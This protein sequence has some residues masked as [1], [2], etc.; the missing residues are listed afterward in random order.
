MTPSP[1]ARRRPFGCPP[2]PSVAASRLVMALVLLAVTTGVAAQT[3]EALRPGHPRVYTVQPGDTLWTIAG[4]FLND[5][6]RWREV[7]QA[8]PGVGN[9]NLIFPGDVLE[10]TYDAGGRARIRSKGGTRVV[11]LSPRIRVTEIDEAIP[12]IP[13]SVIAPFLSRPMVS[14]SKEIDGAPYV[15]SFP[16][17]RIVASAGDQFFVR[18]VLSSDNDRYEVLRPGQELI[19]PDTDEVLGYEATFVAEAKLLRT[20]DPATLEVMRGRREVLAGDRIWPARDNT[21]VR[22]FTP[23]AAPFGIEGRIIGVL[24]GVSQIGQYDVVALNRGER[25]HVA[26]G[27]VFEVF[28][29][30]ELRSDKVRAQRRDWN[31]RNETPLD[32]SFWFGDWEP[33]GWK[34][35]PWDEQGVPVQYQRR[36]DRQTT[37]YI[38]PD[39]RAGVVMVFRTFP[40]VSYA[41]VMSATQSIIVGQIVAPPRD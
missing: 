21:P 13:I 40:R 35:P 11:K 36:T 27:H 17:R 14:A 2:A 37:R 18:K 10:V 19:D 32:T 31:W 4:Q 6:W 25:D 3:D 15:V 33:S 1:S 5:P 20:G 39:E 23:E 41:L 29:G 26:M 34:N 38:V 22:S 8:N 12:T 30:G 7:W 16:E 9:P 24:G 28:S